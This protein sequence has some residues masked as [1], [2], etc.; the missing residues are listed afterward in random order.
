MSARR[1]A[2]FIHPHALFITHVVQHIEPIA[3]D[4]VVAPPPASLHP[5]PWAVDAPPR[6]P[7]APRAGSAAPRPPNAP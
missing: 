2:I 4:D 5:S 3:R 7:E 1:D 6:P